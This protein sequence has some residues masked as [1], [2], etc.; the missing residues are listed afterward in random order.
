MAKIGGIISKAAFETIPSSLSWASKNPV[1]VLRIA[2]D[3]VLL[4]FAIPEKRESIKKRIEKEI[5]I[6]PGDIIKQRP[7]GLSVLLSTL[8]LLLYL[9]VYY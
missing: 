3:T 4:K 2:A 7:I 5:K 1:A 9:I 6:Y 8:F